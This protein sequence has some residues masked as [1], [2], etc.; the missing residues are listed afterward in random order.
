MGLF[1]S[2]YN[3]GHSSEIY[4][5][6]VLTVYQSGAK[7]VLV[8]LLF[9]K[10]ERSYML[11]STLVLFICFLFSYKAE[12]RDLP[13]SKPMK[14]GFFHVALF[15]QYGPGSNLGF[16]SYVSGSNG[17]PLISPGAAQFGTGSVTT[18]GVEFLFY[19]TEISG[20]S[21]GYSI[22]SARDIEHKQINYESGVSTRTYFYP[23]DKVQNST[24][25]FNY[26]FVHTPDRGYLLL[27]LNYSNPR[28]IQSTTTN[29]QLTVSGDLGVQASI[30]FSLVKGV[31]FD[32]TARTTTIKM[33]STDP[34]LGT[35]EDFGRGQISEGLVGFKFIF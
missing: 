5:P 34:V 9:K 24:T 11:Y 27:G 26:Y 6:E 21:F 20:F 4:F 15:G 18:A 31:I 32:I 8:K 28:W 13:I 7:I 2:A 25:S 19:T 12:S 33:K 10:A 22:D 16:G 17:S 30:G 35:F 29:A 1:E 23:R 3:R 14:D